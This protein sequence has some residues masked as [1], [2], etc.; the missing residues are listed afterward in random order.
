ML[1]VMEAAVE[2][3]RVDRPRGPAGLVIHGA[4]DPHDVYAVMR[5]G[6]AGAWGFEETSFDAFLTSRSSV[7]GH[8]P[9][10]WFLASVDGRPAGAMTVFPAAPERSAMQ[11]GELAV[12]PGERRHG[13]ATALVHQAFEVTRAA[14][15]RLLYLFAD[16]DS[17]DDAPGLYRSS[18]FEVVQSTV[19]L[20]AP[21]PLPEMARDKPE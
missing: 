13:V 11:L 18:G 21:L 6:F 1:W 12:L 16:S 14:G 2:A 17:A 4:A 19:L 15:M 20:V 5:A 3:E 9:S 8:D 10:L 7:P